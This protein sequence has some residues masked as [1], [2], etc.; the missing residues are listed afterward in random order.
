[1]QVTAACPSSWWVS[2]SSGWKISQDHI[3]PRV[4]CWRPPMSPLLKLITLLGAD[5]E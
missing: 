3:Q 2:L 1:M 4:Q 5:E